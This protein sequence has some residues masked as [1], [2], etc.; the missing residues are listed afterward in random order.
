[1]KKKGLVILLV[2]LLGSMFL[3]N[4]VYSNEGDYLGWEN[5][6]ND[7]IG[8][9]KLNLNE[10]VFLQV[11]DFQ[12]GPYIGFCASYLERV[13]HSMPKNSGDFWEIYL[14]FKGKR[15]GSSVKFSHALEITIN[16][17][18][19][20]VEAKKG[21][22]RKLVLMNG[23]IPLFSRITIGEE[24]NV[25]DMTLPMSLPMKEANQ[26]LSFFDSVM[27]EFQKRLEDPKLNVKFNFFDL[28]I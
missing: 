19:Y 3:G 6:K 23:R 10:E 27:V 17:W 15:N 26:S 1:M 28:S 11:S 2:V 4:I 8:F 18:H 20:D 22:C 16:Y 25:L 24:E 9:P 14:V 21:I 12:G 13:G 5:W 7:F